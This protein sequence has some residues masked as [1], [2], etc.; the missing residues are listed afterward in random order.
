VFVVREPHP[1][2]AGLHRAGNGGGPGAV[3]LGSNQVENISS[4]SNAPLL[5]ASRC[6]RLRLDTQFR[7]H[8]EIADWPARLDKTYQRLS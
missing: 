5:V 6:S 8:K 3:A 4:A 2:H 1:S 7:M